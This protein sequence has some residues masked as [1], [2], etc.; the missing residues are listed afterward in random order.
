MFADYQAEVLRSYHTKK[1][2]NA[3]SLKLIHPT[4]AKLRDAC[5]ETVNNRLLRK[6][7]NAIRSFFGDYGDATAYVKAIRK[8]DVDSF[9]PLNKFLRGDIKS[10]DAKNIELLAWL[11]DF[12]PR[13]Y[14][15]DSDL[16]IKMEHEIAV[17]SKEKGI[18]KHEVERESS[19]PLQESTVVTRVPAK[20]IRL[21]DTW[22]VAVL[23]AVTLLLGAVGFLYW[24]HNEPEEC[25]IWTVDRYRPVSC[26]QKSGNMLIMAL[27]TVKVA[28]FKKIMRPD[29]ITAN[30]L[31]RVWYSKIDNEV[32]F[33]T[34]DGYHPIHTERRLKPLTLYM[35]N[36]YIVHK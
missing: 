17:T 12:E 8:F 29:T 4:P 24:G 28:H 25:M 5:E 22:K 2:E 34:S 3:I 35:L 36:K 30:S 26:S 32:E 1:A 23:I 7:M 20:E 15:A 21:S 19:Q 16:F 18:E 13:P 10:T 11:I 33:F 9:R 6:D 27:D 14:R 31:G